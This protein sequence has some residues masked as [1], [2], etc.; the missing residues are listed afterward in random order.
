MEWDPTSLI[1]TLT[2]QYR[3]ELLARIDATREALDRCDA[4]Q[5][6][7]G[8]PSWVR[9]WSVPWPIYLRRVEE[10]TLEEVD[11]GHGGEMT[12]RFCESAHCDRHPALPEPGRVR[13]LRESIGAEWAEEAVGGGR[14]VAVVRP[15]RERLSEVQGTR[16]TRQGP[17]CPVLPQAGRCATCSCERARRRGTSP[18][19]DWRHP[20][21]TTTAGLVSRWPCSRS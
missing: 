12:V 5:F 8:A 16:W 1:A 15:G 6:D 2:P 21:N 14:E 7:N 17:A 13:P 10:E 3:E 9:D 4:L 11:V 19:P 18:T 20:R